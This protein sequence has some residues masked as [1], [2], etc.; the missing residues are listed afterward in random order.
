MREE[1]TIYEERVYGFILRHWRERGMPPTFAEML[2]GLGGTSRCGLARWVCGLEKKGYIKKEKGRAR[3]IVFCPPVEERPRI[4]DEFL[5]PEFNE[6]AWDGVAR[7]GLELL[8]QGY[9]INKVYECCSYSNGLFVK[10]LGHIDFVNIME[11]IRGVCRRFVLRPP[12]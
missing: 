4:T 3:A 11:V 9:H 6:R 1:R 7:V 8:R 10:P 2:D 12:D 5:S